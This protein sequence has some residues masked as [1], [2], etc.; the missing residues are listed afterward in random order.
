MHLF[1]N[2]RFLTRPMTGVDRVAMELSRALREIIE[3]APERVIT[4]EQ[5]L[6]KSKTHPTASV[7]RASLGPV[8]VP[9]TPHEH[10]LDRGAVEARPTTNHCPLDATRRSPLLPGQF[11]E[12]CELPFLQRDAWLLSLC[13]VG[14]LIRR[15]QVIMIHDAQV[16]D[17][18]QSY[19]LPFRLW[20]KC[21]LPRLARRA[22]IVLTVS[23][24][25]KQRLEANGVV[26][27]GKAQVLYNGVDHMDAIAADDTVL[28]KH[29]LAPE[30]Y[31]LALG[32]RAR[33]KN[34]AMLI[35]AAKQRPA[36]SPPLIIAGGGDANVFASE[37]LISDENVRFIGR[38]SDGELKALYTNALAF[39]F[40][41]IT[42]GFGLPPMEAMRCGCP[43]IATTGG[44]VPEICGDAAIYA[45]PNDPSAWTLALR[46][47]NN[48]TTLRSELSIKGKRQSECY[49]WQQSAH[50][51]LEKLAA[52]DN[53]SALIEHLAKSED[54]ATFVEA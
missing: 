53:D 36:N 8:S 49:T 26:P 5:T 24:H 25:S 15:R 6:P 9:T 10:A 31:I 18:P 19:S 48:E 44:A 27:A 7:G 1:L 17:S 51:L 50:Q 30:G 37:G 22:Q 41:S 52:M 35:Q 23:E 43:V 16:W 29:G 45:D 40:P 46:R 13:S 32:S 21:L 38:V 11:W 34:L 54:A 12:Q 42:E 2:A 3:A 14:P 28:S 47:I 4:L 39:A 33:H 20:Y